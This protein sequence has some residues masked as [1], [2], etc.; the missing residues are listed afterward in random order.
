MDRSTTRYSWHTKFYVTQS[1]T[2]TWSIIIG[3]VFYIF[4]GLSQLRLVS[5]RVSTTNGTRT[6]LANATLNLFIAAAVI[7]IVTDTYAPSH[8][9]ISYTI[10]RSTVD[11][12][13]YAYLYSHLQAARSRNALLPMWL[14]NMENIWHCSIAAILCSIGKKWR[15]SQSGSLLA[16][17]QERRPN[18][19]RT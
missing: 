13:R 9:A 7:S 5:W 3:S 16:I 19:L 11:G 8:S 18:T 4:L 17:V 6:N 1:Q 15:M 12:I 14:K 2:L 10:N